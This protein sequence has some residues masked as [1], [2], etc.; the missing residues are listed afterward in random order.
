MKIAIKRINGFNYIDPEICYRTQSIKDE[1]GNITTQLLFSEDVLKQQ[2]Y[3]Y[4]F[5]DIDDKYS[6]CNSFDFDYLNGQFSFNEN[7]YNKRKDIENKQKKLYELENWFDSYFEKQLIQSMWQQ[8]FIVSRDNYFDKS[9]T[10]IDELKT[11]GEIVRAE[12]KQL[13]SRLNNG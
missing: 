4:S 10:T 11:Q 3:N 5:I 12:I 2:P 13:R 8:N 6:D 9:Y 7:K 1:Q